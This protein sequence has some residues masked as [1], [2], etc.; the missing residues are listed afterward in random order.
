MKHNELAKELTK[1]HRAVGKRIGGEIY[2]HTSAIGW[3]QDEH[4]QLID[5]AC[6]MAE[7][8]LDDPYNVVKISVKK[9][10]VSLLQY[11]DFFTDPFPVLMAA[12]TIDLDSGKARKTDYTKSDNPPILHRK[13]LLLAPGDPKIDQF[14]NLTNELESLG[15]YR[16][17]RR[18]GFRKQWVG[19]LSAAG[20][21]VKNH[22]VQK[23]QPS[24][25]AK[26]QQP[27]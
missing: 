10:R 4:A 13:E 26:D 1:S 9:R 27:W 17:S 19:R 12:F 11:S 25:L 2:V 3:L 18:I 6:A 22:R 23:V 24:L 7:A 5:N 16:D 20:V 8:V 14:S 21:R 15:L